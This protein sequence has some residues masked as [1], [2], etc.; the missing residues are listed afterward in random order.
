MNPFFEETMTAIWTELIRGS[1]EKEHPFRMPV[2]GTSGGGEEEPI[3]NNMRMVV[4]RNVDA[5]ERQLFFHTDIRSA[6]VKDLM[7][8]PKLSWLFYHPRHQIQ[9]RAKG[10]IQLHFKDKVWD[11]FWQM[12]TANSLKGYTTKVAPGTLLIDYHPSIE[13]NLLNQT[14]EKG[15]I[16]SG[17]NNFVVVS[18]VIEFVEW[19]KL[20]REGHQRIE[21]IWK[22]GQ[23]QACWVA[24]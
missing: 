20:S 13:A 17:K 19:L 12:G 22:N 1:A 2:I 23:W 3:E 14:P 6:K 8:Y 16:E 24:P 5:Q 7:K 10:S 18:C 11:D 21:F 9:I 15:E 4:L